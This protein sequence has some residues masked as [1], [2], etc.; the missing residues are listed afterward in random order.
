MAQAPDEEQAPRKTTTYNKFEGMASQNERYNVKQN[1]MFWIENIMRT[2]PR[3]LS[4]VPGPTFRVNLPKALPCSDSTQRGQQ[5]LSAVTAFQQQGVAPGETPPFGNDR[6][7][8]AFISPSGEVTTLN[9]VGT[10]GG[11]N[12][13]YVATCCQLN[14]FIDNIPVVNDHPGLILP[15]NSLLAVNARIGISDQPAYAINSNSVGGGGVRIWYSN[16]STGVDYLKPAGYTG[17]DIAAWCV[18]GN[19]AWLSA[20]QS[21]TFTPARMLVKFNRTSGAFI[22]D[23]ATVNTDLISNMNLTAANLI[24][25]THDMS[26]ADKYAIK[27]IDRG[28]GALVQTIDLSNLHPSFLFA[29]N[30]NLIYVL[31]GQGFPSFPAKLYYWDGSNLVYVGIVS[32]FTQ[33]PFTQGVGIFSGGRYYWG[34]NG[35]GGSSVDIFSFAVA[36]P[37][38]SPLIAAVTVGAS[39]VAAGGTISVSWA[40]VLEPNKIG[41]DRI[42]LY[43]APSAG[44]L[45]FFI[46]NAVAEQVTGGAGSGTITFTIPG[47]TALGS[48][49]FRYQAGFTGQGVLVATSPSFTVT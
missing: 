46:A 18:E 3:K 9:G 7:S 24:C 39:S 45:D 42:V 48:Y 6:T 28:S 32:N 40:N 25:L 21:A 27:K 15:D 41:N 11:G 10:C 38:E 37:S 23:Y 30:D 44:N 22:T 29:V 36:C 43:P 12:M 26:N 47:G 35:F 19:E 16:S 2:G 14:H 49:V 13:N 5:S 1:E 17:F 34:N 20:N 4:S 31:C 8:W 33:L